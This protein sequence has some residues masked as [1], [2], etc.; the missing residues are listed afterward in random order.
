MLSE[1]YN[2]YKLNRH[3]LFLF[4]AEFNLYKMDKKILKI[5]KKINKVNNLKDSYIN[6]DNY[7]SDKFESILLD[8]KNKNKELKEY[9]KYIDD[10]NKI[11]LKFNDKLNDID[12]KTEK[13]K[14]KYDKLKKKINTLNSKLY[15]AKL[16]HKEINDYLVSNEVNYE[17]ILNSKDKKLIDEY[18]KL[19]NIKTKKEIKYDYLLNSYTS[20]ND[21]CNK[22]KNDVDVEGLKIAKKNYSISKAKERRKMILTENLLKTVLIIC[23]PIALYQFFNSLY[24]LLDQIICAQISTTAQNAVS[25]IS[26]IKN[27][28]SSFGAGIAAGGG[29]LVSRYYGAGDIK[30][31]RHSSSNLFFLSIIISALLCFIMIPLA[32]PIMKICQIAE[33]SIKIGKTYFMLQMLELAFVA[34]N[35]VFI[36]LEKAK[37]NSKSILKLNLLVLIV[38]MAFTCFFVFGCNLKDIKYVEIATI[39]G[40]ATLTTIGLIVLFSKGNI[41]RLSVK[42]LLPKKEYIIPI[43]K[44]SIPIFLGKFVMSMGKV[45]VNGMC[46]KYWNEVTDGLI[47][48]TL[49]VSNNICGLITS[50]TNSFEEGESSIVSQNLGAKNIKRAMKSFYRTLIVATIVSLVGYILLRFILIDQVVSLFTSADEKSEAYKEMVKQIFKWDSLSIISLGICAAVLGL[51]YGFGQTGLSTILNLSRIGSRIIILFVLHNFRPDLSPTFC[52]GLSMGISNTII[53]GLS[54]I[55]LLIFIIKIKI[56]GYK[57]MRFNDPEP[58]YSE[59]DI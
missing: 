6:S 15:E 17:T 47:V 45:V 44:L 4:S 14:N 55:F 40:Q 30:R 32:V 23:M 25:S 37:G 13:N 24:T 36:G 12:L 20:N 5:N 35:N 54:I 43:F 9:K 7:I 16:K 10:L 48:G 53:L 26:Q 51:L 46:G 38:K 41:L 2:K 42:S 18:I 8:Y 29:V 52:A 19:N 39:L 58:K 49:G 57:D 50:P 59:L 28:I 1:Y 27:T 21:K 56:K 22:F 31:A 34:L 3:G 33:D 11:I